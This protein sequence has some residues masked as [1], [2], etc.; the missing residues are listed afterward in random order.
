MARYVD[1]IIEF[2]LELD[3]VGP[4]EKMLLCNRINQRPT[5][6]ELNEARLQAEVGFEK[7]LKDGTGTY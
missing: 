2:I 6:Q 3:G 4:I 5:Q 1:R 7:Y